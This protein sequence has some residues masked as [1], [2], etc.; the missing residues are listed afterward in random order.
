MKD[1]RV[2]VYLTIGVGKYFQNVW[3]ESKSLSCKN[4]LNDKQQHIFYVSMSLC[5]RSAQKNVPTLIEDSR[6]NGEY[7][8]LNDTDF[9]N[10]G[11]KPFPR[12]NHTETDIRIGI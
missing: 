1:W 9:P 3:T 8:T 7:F 11:I 10:L 4:T 12:S 2:R 6:W 5:Q